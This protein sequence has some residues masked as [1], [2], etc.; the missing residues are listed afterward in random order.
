MDREHEFLEYLELQDEPTF[1]TKSELLD[2]VRGWGG[3][4]GDRRLTFYVSEGLIPKSVRIGSR[5]G[6]YPEVVADLL[7]WINRFRARGVSVE[8]LRELVPIWRYLRR[9][10]KDQIL[11]LTEFEYMARQHLSSPEAVFNLPALVFSVL[12]DYCGDCRSKLTV[13]RKDGEEL[14]LRR[15]PSMSFVVTDPGEES[16][17]FVTSITVPVGDQLEKDPTSICLEL[18]AEQSE[19]EAVKPTVRLPVR[20]EGAKKGGGRTRRRAS[21]SKS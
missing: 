1:I 13:R 7:D 5:A 2:R 8:A 10:G 9:A 14:P 19:S 15:S 21:E 16:A 3:R 12:T 20:G 11:D 17:R 4:I 6:A 18:K